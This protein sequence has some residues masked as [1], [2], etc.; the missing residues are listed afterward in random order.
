M[1]LKPLDMEKNDAF[2]KN[3]AGKP[4]NLPTEELS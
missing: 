4:E 2:S 3:G 1:V